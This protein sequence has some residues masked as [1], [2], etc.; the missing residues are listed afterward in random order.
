MSVPSTGFTRHR[1]TARDSAKIST[2]DCIPWD[3]RPRDWQEAARDQLEAIIGTLLPWQRVATSCGTYHCCQRL[4]LRSISA[5]QINY[6]KYVCIYCGLPG[7]TKD[8]LLPVTVTGGAARDWVA[9]VPACGQCNS[10]I[11]ERI[12]HRVGERRDFVHECLRRKNK[13]MLDK[14]KLTEADLAEFGP[15]LRSLIQAMEDKRDVLLQRLAWPEPGYDERAF[16]KTGI[17]DPYGLDL[18]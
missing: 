7:Y 13:K 1:N 17:E 14:G 11:G 8:H 16:V 4:H 5:R 18:I 6:P 12:G 2:R 9:V 10:I 3:G 15:N